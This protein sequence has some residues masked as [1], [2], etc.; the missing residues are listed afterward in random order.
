MMQASW[1]GGKSN[2]LEY[3]KNNPP[4]NSK[5]EL[6]SMNSLCNSGNKTHTHTHTHTHTKESTIQLMG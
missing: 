5:E 6:H 3:K 1:N 4:F 2:V